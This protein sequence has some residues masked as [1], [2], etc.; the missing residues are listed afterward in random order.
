MATMGVRGKLSHFRGIPK[1]AFLL[2]RAMKSLYAGNLLFPPVI[3]IFVYMLKKQL[4]F[5]QVS[6]FREKAF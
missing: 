3:Q 1:S 4:L 2:L 5:K 6:A